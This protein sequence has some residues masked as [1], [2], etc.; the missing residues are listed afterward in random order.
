[1]PR[2][3]KDTTMLFS[4]AIE[5]TEFRKWVFPSPY[6]PLITMLFDKPLEASAINEAALSII[7]FLEEEKNLPTEREGTPDLRASIICRFSKSVIF[8]P[9]SPE[10]YIYWS[11]KE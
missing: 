4:C 10:V 3:T 2:A 1:M 7:S 5:N 8:K 11:T 9:P 6:F